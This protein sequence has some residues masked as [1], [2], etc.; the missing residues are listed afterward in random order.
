MT[1]LI[2]IIAGVLALYRATVP[3]ISNLPNTHPGIG[4]L[5]WIS[6]ISL[7]L[8]AAALANRASHIWAFVGSFLVVV[9]YVYGIFLLPLARK[10]GYAHAA[11]HLSLVQE[12]WVD[13]WRLVLDRPVWI[14]LLVFGCIGLWLSAR[15]LR[16]SRS[17]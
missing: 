14:L 10:L 12:N 17:H 2:Y 11:A 9:V 13:R 3:L 15:A 6:A 5:F 16:S 8:A 1:R 7:F 4:I